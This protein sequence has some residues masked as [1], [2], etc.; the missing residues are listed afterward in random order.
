ML[1]ALHGLRPSI[2]VK[3][4][5]VLAD[6]RYESPSRYDYVDD[7]PY[8]DEYV[9]EPSIWKLMIVMNEKNL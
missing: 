2:Y 5:Q 1:F 9:D 7:S 3:R 8:V 6:S 4:D